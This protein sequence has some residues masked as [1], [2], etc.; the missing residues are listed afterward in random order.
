MITYLMR[1][2]EVWCGSSCPS[3]FLTFGWEASHLR[4]A[5][6]YL[7]PVSLLEEDQ[8]RGQKSKSD[9]QSNYHHD[10]LPVS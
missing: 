2:P 5:L 7:A 3:G 8:K 6:I 10:P 1:S 9:G 4:T